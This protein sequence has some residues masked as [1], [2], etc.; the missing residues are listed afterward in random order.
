[1][2][3]GAILQ[4]RVSTS[5]N[6]GLFR[7]KENVKTTSLPQSSKKRFQNHLLWRKNNIYDRTFLSFDHEPPT[8][9]Y[10]RNV[11]VEML[12]AQEALQTV[13]DATGTPKVKTVKSL[14]NTFLT[15]L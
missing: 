12:C 13:K 5:L 2:H 6:E 14:E 1:M 7:K 10:Q 9:N 8:T 11:A 3:L 15:F 4:T